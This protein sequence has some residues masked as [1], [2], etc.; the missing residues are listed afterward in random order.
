MNIQPKSIVTVFVRTGRPV[1]TGAGASSTGA[2]SAPNSCGT[3]GPAN[4]TA[5]PPRPGRGPSP[6]IRRS[7]S[8]SS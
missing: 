5:K 3:P 4:S 8:K 1:P 7:N 2:A 6:R